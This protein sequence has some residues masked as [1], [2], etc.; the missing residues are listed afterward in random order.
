M[1]WP[2]KPSIKPAKVMPTQE[3]WSTSTMS[4]RMAGSKAPVTKWLIYITSIV[5][6]HPAGGW[7][8]LLAFLGVTVGNMSTTCIPLWRGPQLYGSFF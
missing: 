1:I 4:G 5:N 2:V 6:F 7:I 3:A 8:W